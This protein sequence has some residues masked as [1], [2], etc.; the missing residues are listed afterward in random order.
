MR[1]LLCIL[2]LS[3]ISATAFAADVKIA[4]FN[5]INQERKV[6]EICGVVSN[7]SSTPSFVRITVDHTS[8]R[9]AVY[10]AI[11][12]ADGKFCA[13]VISYYGVAEAAAL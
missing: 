4:S 7:T 5:Y 9:P 3:L 2:S 11:A 10:N 13:V 6:A 1:K 8:K 12:G